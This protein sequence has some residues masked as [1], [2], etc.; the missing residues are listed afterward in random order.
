MRA[1]CA[2]SV[3][4]LCFESYV[5]GQV[6]FVEEISDDGVVSGVKI[7]HVGCDQDVWQRLT[8]LQ[9]GNS[10]ELKLVDHFDGAQREEKF[11]HSFFSALR[12]RNEWFRPEPRLREFIASCH[13]AKKLDLVGL[14]PC[15]WSEDK[16]GRR[17]RTSQTCL[18]CDRCDRPETP[19]QTEIRLRV[20]ERTAALEAA[21]TK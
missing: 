14:A 7:G 6:Y 4:E 13:R 10:R 15:I 20:E 1:W 21:K 19:T 5:P 16:E 2:G 18:W 8:V 12:I 11:L 3:D 9:T 17:S